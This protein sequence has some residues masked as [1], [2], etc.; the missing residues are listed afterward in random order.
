MKTVWIAN[1]EAI[2]DHL[3]YAGAETYDWYRQLHDTNDEQ[4]VCQMETGETD[5]AT[6]EPLLVK[7]TF[8]PTHAK[9]VVNAIIKEQKA[10]WQ[11]VQRAVNSDDFDADASDVVLQHIVLG[12]LVFG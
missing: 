8:S 11:V 9:T 4:I 1:A 2:I 6:G 3:C 10:G 5:D 7:V 12:D